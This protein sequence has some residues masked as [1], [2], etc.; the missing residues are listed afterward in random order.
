MQKFIYILCF[1][2]SSIS[3]QSQNNFN[4][5]DLPKILVH[6]LNK[7]RLANNL[8][9]F[10][11]NPIL[12]EAASIDAD[13]FSDD[14]KV[15]VDQKIAKRNLMSSGG[16]NKGEELAII[17]PISKGRDNYTTEQVAKTVWTRWENNKKD[18]EITISESNIVQP[19]KPFGTKKNLLRD[20]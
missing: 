11:L 5:D 19:S 15:K 13:D 8:D 10:E 1:I 16:T 9:T 2:F 7:F 20:L 3:I 14:G 6:E 18:K 12:T 17:A 4:I